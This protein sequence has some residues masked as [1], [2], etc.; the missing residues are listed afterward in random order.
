MQTITKGHYKKL[1][2]KSRVVL[3]SQITAEQAERLERQQTH[4]LRQIFRCGLSANKMRER[5]GLERLTD[6]IEEKMR[7][8]SLPLSVQK[9]FV[10][11][12]D[13]S[14]KERL[15]GMGGGIT[16]NITSLLN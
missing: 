3:H 2:A 11:V 4:S 1:D 6:K 14:L 7:A 15:L 12:M 13:G 16:R 10:S 9:T 8:R 5:A